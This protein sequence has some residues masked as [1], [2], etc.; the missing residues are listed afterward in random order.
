[1]GFV[2]VLPFSSLE[3]G[4]SYFTKKSCPSPPCFP[5]LPFPPP[6]FFAESLKFPQSRR[7]RPEH[8]RELRSQRRDLLSV[9]HF[10]PPFPA[11]P[12][13]SW[14]FGTVCRPGGNAQRRVIAA[15]AE[16]TESRGEGTRGRGAG[17]DCVLVAERSAGLL[18]A[19][20][21]AGVVRRCARPAGGG[22]VSWEML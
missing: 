18:P 11:L 22:C 20:A 5:F 21:L 13:P 17:N 8:S 6:P 1:M 15:R 19:K 3:V 9:S 12:L 14:L 4:R 7:P 10:S 16:E 2:V